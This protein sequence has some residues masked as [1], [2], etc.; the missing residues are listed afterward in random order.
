MDVRK[1]PEVD[2][3]DMEARLAEPVCPSSAGARWAAVAGLAGAWFAAGSTGLLGYAL[4]RGLTW[5]AIGCVALAGWRKSERP[6]VL[7]L[8]LAGAVVAAVAIIASELPPLH[9]FAVVL[10]LVATAQ[11]H[12]GSRRA[13]ILLAAE[14]VA[15]LGLYRIAY[16]SIGWF[17]LACDAVGSALGAAAGWITAHPLWVGA[18]FAG[19][20]FLV[21]ML[22]LAIRGPIALGG[23]PSS[24]GTTIFRVGVGVGAVLIGHF[25][26]LNVLSFAP[27]ITAALPEPPPP[28]DSWN[29][30]PLP[31]GFHAKVDQWVKGWPS[32]SEPAVRYVGENWPYLGQT[33]RRIVPWNMPLLAMLIHL[34]IGWAIFR[35]LAASGVSAEPAKAVR[36]V[37]PWRNL[38]LAGTAAVLALLFPVVVTLSW[39]HPNLSNKKFVF[40]DQGIENFLRPRHG[41]GPANYGWLSVGMY[42]MSADYLGTL[43]ANALVTKQVTA[44]DLEDASVLVVFLHS[45]KD[46]PCDEEFRKTVWEFVGRGGTLLVLADHTME[47]LDESGDKNAPAPFRYLNNWVN[48]LLAPTRIRVPFDTAELVLPGWLQSF[49]AISHPASAGVKDRGNQYGVVTGASVDPRWPASP[50]LVGRFGFNDWGDIKAPPQH[51]FM[52]QRKYEAGAKLGDCILAAEQPYGA[53]RVVVFGDT[54]G[55]INPNVATI[56]PYLFRLYA[57][58]ADPAS[59]PQSPWRQVLGMVLCVALLG[60]L[61]AWPSPGRWA[62][63][64]AGAAVSLAV[65]TAVTHSAWTILPSGSPMERRVPA[66][67]AAMAARL[68]TAGTP[69]GRMHFPYVNL[70]GPNNL[71]YIDDCHMSAFSHD[72]W[73]PEGIMGLLLTLMRNDFVPLMA[74]ETTSERL[75]DARLLVS[76]APG[77]EYTK[78]EREAIVEWVNKGGLFICTVGYDRAGPVESLLSEFRIDIG[79]DPEDLE[80]KQGEPLPIGHIKTP[81]FRGS[82]YM[83]MVRF[84]AGW[85]IDAR[86]RLAMVL[87]DYPGSPNNSPL[88]LVRPRGKGL[89]VVVGDTEFAFNKNLENRNGEPFEGLRENAVFWRWLISYLR[90]GVGEGQVWFPPKRTPEGVPGPAEPADNGAVEPPAPP[91]AKSS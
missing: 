59:T 30:Y 9:V 89:V 65:C 12:T 28:P 18:T 58:L 6:W 66:A 75:R 13:T 53:G 27:S 45:K 23:R 31:R 70:T 29:P 21:V 84:W 55:F 73:K 16:T 81:F 36:R 90:E 64:A 78:A 19:L 49:E 42:G 43:G 67:G 15:V 48:Q 77:K 61:L 68:S 17:W 37:P 10:V 34:A 40:L 2:G 50:I 33:L 44:S 85:P 71:A 24:A 3:R 51:G 88:I 82:D 56:H 74:P 80:I 20:D 35:H 62:L 8:C 11:G 22:Y 83:A 60:V 76:I 14:A 63:A 72:P 79:G 52:G 26:Y 25:I 38:G 86:D 54:T 91:P 47:P 1:S 57:Y 5:A 41:E 4:R 39:H 69:L 32:W 7:V 46:G 87:S